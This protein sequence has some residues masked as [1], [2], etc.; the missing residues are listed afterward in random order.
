MKVLVCP[1]N[2]GLGH[3]TRCV[4]I[5]RQL[6]ADGHEVVI[7]SDAYP[8][9]FLK[10]EFPS[11][12]FI[13]YSSFT[14]YYSSSNSQIIAM[15]FNSPDI[16][17]GIYEEH[18][19]LKNLLL[20][21]HFD[22]IISDNRFGIWS[23]NVYSI[24]ITHQIM[25]KMPRRL[26]LFEPII[27]I[28]HRLIMNRYNEC[29]IPDRVD[30]NSGLSGDLSHKYPLPKNARFIGAQSRFTGMK[31]I[32]Q[33]TSYD[34]VGIV[35]G[36]EPQRTIFENYLINKYKSEPYKTLIVSGQ[37]EKENF[38]KTKGNISIFSHLSD[39]DLASFLVGSKK[40]ICRSGY[41]TIMDLETLN[42]LDKAEFI[43]TPGQTEQEYLAKIHAVKK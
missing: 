18:K 10:Q 15:L 4:P 6:V 43:P 2:W 25:V 39:N 26:K 37:P 29:W 38:K 33:D 31:N 21:E 27:W 13:D 24:Y 16:I 9:E 34:V 42:C 41:S 8:L 17:Y 30:D 19:W 36:P 12:R 11:L 20:S 14:V 28:I 3:A 5:I 22:Q 40:I 32:Q 23:K 35:S 1:L 7:V